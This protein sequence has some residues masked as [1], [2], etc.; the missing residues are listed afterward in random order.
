MQNIILT[1]MGVLVTLVLLGAGYAIYELTHQQS[2]TIIAVS[3]VTSVITAMRSLYQGQGGYGTGSLTATGI[4]AGVF[5]QGMVSGTGAGATVH[6]N[7][8]GSVALQGTGATFTLTYGGVPKQSCVK[9]S[10]S[11]KGSSIQGVTVNGTAVT[12]VAGAASA[13]SNTT[14]SIVWTSN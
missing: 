9:L 2:G 10:T 5:P 6:D 12:D 7:W 14:N 13:C 1:L 4:N 3:N 11:M 8:G